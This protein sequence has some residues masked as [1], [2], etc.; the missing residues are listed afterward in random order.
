MSNHKHFYEFGP[1]RL[2]ADER[3]VLRSGVELSL[4]NDGR[5]ERLPPKAFDLL[6]LLVRNGNRMVGREE[7]IEQLWPGTFVE[8]NR[9]SDNI[10]ILRKFLGDNARN[11]EFIETVP[12]HGYRFLTDVRVV[13]DEVVAFVEETRAHIV[14][15][16]SDEQTKQPRNLIATNSHV[17]NWRTPVLVGS[18]LVVLVITGI[19]WM[20]RSS[21]HETKVPLLLKTSQFTSETT[22]EFDPAISPDGKLIAFSRHDGQ[23]EQIY[24]KQVGAGEALQLTYTARARNGAST[25]SP[26]GLLIAYIHFPNL[27]LE[28]QAIFTVPALGGPSRKVFSNKDFAFGPGLDWSPDGKHLAFSARSKPQEAQAVY[29]LNLA[30]QETRRITSPTHLSDVDNRMEFSPDGKVLAFVRTSTSGQGEIYRVNLPDGQ[31]QRLTNDNRSIIGMSWTADGQSIVFSSNRAGGG[32]T[33]WKVAADGGTP[34]PVPI[35][36]ENALNPSVSRI[37][38]RI[39]FVK[40]N[41]DTNVWRLDLSNPKVGPTSLISSSRHDRN[42]ALSPDGK[43]IAFESS[44]TGNLEIWM[45]D[46]DGSNSIQLTN[47]D[48]PIASNPSWSPD[49]QYLAYEARPDGHSD[50]FVMR[51]ED[52]NSRRLTVEGSNE[53]S[54]S[55]S[56]DGKLIYFA[57]DRSGTTEVWSMSAQGGAL[58][59]VTRNGGYEAVESTDGKFLYYSKF[60]TRG[61]FRLPINGGDEQLV[62]DLPDLVSWGDWF[63]ASDGIYFLDRTLTPRAEIRFHDF[64]SNVARLVASLDKDPS[65]DPGLTVTLD[66]RTLIFS[67]YDTVNND[68]MLVENFR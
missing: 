10:S 43:K 57:S 21:S 27:G 16:E 55:W 67:R 60:R 58:T 39:A 2:D 45:C 42:P 35:G 47:F 25:W 23:Q 13:T 34:E 30:S 29:L 3:R 8:E 31:E 63:V 40:A 41:T 20:R 64:S 12:K 51:V 65:S 66:R 61:I 5:I 48:G 56:R 46:Y 22:Q 9:L 18:L 26:D 68:I 54:P 7:L 37:G 19:F 44:R 62:I 36:G 1:F 59:Q 32:F 24:V 52:G 50:I 17:V 4:N 28:P 15:E 53:L 38:N 49:G 33:L 14:I 11:P 6:L